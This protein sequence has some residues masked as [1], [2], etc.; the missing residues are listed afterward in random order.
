MEKV[1]TAIESLMKQYRFI[2]HHIEHELT[3]IVD[4]MDN[5]Q[6]KVGHLT[7]HM[8]NSHDSGKTSSDSHTSSSSTSLTESDIKRFIEHVSIY[9]LI[10]LYIFITNYDFI[11]YI[12]FCIIVYQ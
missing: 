10:K 5:L 3:A 9:I 4:Q 11:F 7:E 8:E 6:L 12:L 1:E 2:D